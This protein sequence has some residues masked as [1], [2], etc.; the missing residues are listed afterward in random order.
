MQKYIL[1]S[2]RFKGQ[3]TFGYDHNGDI[4]FYNNEIADEV[5]V[6]WMKRFIPIDKHELETFKTKVQATITEV[7][8]DL[9]FERFWNAYDKKHNRKRTEPLYNKLSDAEKMQA[10]MRIKQYQ[11]YCYLKSRGIADPEKYIRE[12]YFE[13]DWMKLK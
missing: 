10:L 11:E 5:V 4:V 12:R 3:V 7:P 9:T 2:P 8:E 13:T 1:T 6:K